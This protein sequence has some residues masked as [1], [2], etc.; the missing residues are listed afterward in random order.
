MKE[1]I[2]FTVGGAQDMQL[3]RENIAAGHI[4]SSEVITYNG[5]YSDYYFVLPDG[6]CDTVFCPL[7]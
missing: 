2:G 3:F 1:N 7:V 5:V 6:D 4:P